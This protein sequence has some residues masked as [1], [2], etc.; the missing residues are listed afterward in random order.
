MSEDRKDLEK[1]V[2]EVCGNLGVT[3]KEPDD[4]FFDAGGTS[5][6]A[7]RLIARAEEE[8]GEDVLPAEELFTGSTVREI[9]ATLAAKSG[10]PDSVSGRE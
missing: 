10:V 4:D 6:T 3:V 5:L 1:W 8:F 7:T 9:V 2:V